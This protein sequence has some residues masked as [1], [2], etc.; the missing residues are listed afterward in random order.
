MAVFIIPGFFTKKPLYKNLVQSL[1]AAGLATQFIDLGLNV[2]SLE[3][4]TKKV[5]QY[6]NSTPESDDIIAHSFGGLVLKNILVQHPEIIKQIR[7]ISFVAVP[8]R[9]SWASLLVPVWP[10]TLDMLPT[11]AHFKKLSAVPL[12]KHTVNFIPQIDIKIWPNESSRLKSEVDILI[13]KTNHDNII[14]SP[15]LAQNLIKLLN[16]YNKQKTN[17]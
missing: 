13:P 14:K 10:A 1:T 3:A 15:A 8:H 11:K 12:P 9:G 5:L 6:L 17:S 7:S 2:D 16:N 4:T